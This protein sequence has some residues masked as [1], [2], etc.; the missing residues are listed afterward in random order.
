MACWPKCLLVLLEEESWARSRHLLSLNNL[1]ISQESEEESILEIVS[2]FE[3]KAFHL[4]LF[5]SWSS[6]LGFRRGFRN[7]PLLVA[8]S[9][10][11]QKYLLEIQAIDPRSQKWMLNVNCVCLPLCSRL[12]MGLHLSLVFC[13][14]G[15]PWTKVQRSLAFFWERITK[16]TDLAFLRAKLVWMLVL[17]T[18][19]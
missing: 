3:S 9:Q 1:P 2:S 15:V 17:A 16:H 5:C 11:C 13:F 14:L 4:P 19:T 8:S 12:V 10:H 6:D 18:E 7:M